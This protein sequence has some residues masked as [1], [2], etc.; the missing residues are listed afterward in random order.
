L[1]AKIL[2]RLAKDE[3]RHFSFYYNK[4]RTHLEHANAQRLSRFVLKH[5]WM[6]VGE[7][8]KI[9]KLPGMEWF[10]GLRRTRAATLLSPVALD[11]EP[12]SAASSA[13]D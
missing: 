13:G 4:A 7:G 11:S 9:A 12:I 1:L 5:F 8:V 3:R 6:P 2:R 10:E